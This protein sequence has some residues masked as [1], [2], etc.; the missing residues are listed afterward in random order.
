MIDDAAD[1]VADVTKD[2]NAVAQ[3]PTLK[4]LAK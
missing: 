1:V 3:H 4:H 2:A